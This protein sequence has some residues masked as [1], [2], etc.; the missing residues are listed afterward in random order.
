MKKDGHNLI[1]S[2][3]F[4]GVVALGLST[5]STESFAAELDD[6]SSQIPILEQS[7]NIGDISSTDSK[8]QTMKDAAEVVEGDA[9][10]EAGY[11]D[12]ANNAVETKNLDDE[13]S[14]EL[15][16]GG[17]DVLDQAE[18]KNDQVNEVYDDFV[19]EADEAAADFEY[20]AK[21]HGLEEY[22][23]KCNNTSDLQE[24]I[25][26]I[27]EAN[28]V[29]YSEV[30]RLKEE[31]AQ[32]EEELAKINS[33]ETEEYVRYQEASAKYDELLKE[34][35]EIHTEWLAL[36]EELGDGADVSPEVLAEY[37][38]RLNE[39]LQAKEAFEESNA[40][41]D[42]IYY[43]REQAEA[44]AENSETNAENW[45]S[46]LSDALSDRQVKRAAY[47]TADSRLKDIDKDGD[48]DK[49]KE[50][51]ELSAKHDKAYQAKESALNEKTNAEMDLESLVDE[52]ISKQMAV[53]DELRDANGFYSEFECYYAPY[54]DALS[55][56]SKAHDIKTRS[57]DAL[58][59]TRI[60]YSE[61]K[62]VIAEYK[63]NESGAI[64]YK[65]TLEEMQK[66]VDDIGATIDYE[67]AENDN[68]AVR[69]NYDKIAEATD[70]SADEFLKA[71]AENG[72][73]DY[74]SRIAAATTTDEKVALIDEA[75]AAYKEKLDSNADKSG[76]DADEYKALLEELAEYEAKY[77]EAEK[78]YNDAV[79]AYNQQIID[80]R[81]VYDNYQKSLIEQERLLAKKRVLD[82][83]SKE[84]QR[85][86]DTIDEKFYSPYD[87]DWYESLLRE[88]EERI[89]RYEALLF[90][91]KNTI[92]DVSEILGE[93]IEA[94]IQ[95]T[96]YSDLYKKVTRIDSEIE[97]LTAEYDSI[98][99]DLYAPY[100]IV[101]EAGYAYSEYFGD[102]EL[103]RDSAK[104]EFDGVSANL[105]DLQRQRYSY[106]YGED[107]SKIAGL[108][109]AAESYKEALQYNDEAKTLVAKAE[110]LT[111]ETEADYKLTSCSADV[112][113]EYNTVI[114]GKP[115]V[116]KGTISVFT[117]VADKALSSIHN[118]QELCQNARDTINVVVFVTISDI[119]GNELTSV[120][121]A[122]D[123]AA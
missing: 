2:L 99:S 45:Y 33:S 4:G 89:A 104:A 81:E 90:N 105:D 77:A 59:K 40:K 82:K 52:V 26:I 24:K 28:Q 25:D 95:R 36:K 27:D 72:L 117:R 1:K 94:N 86:K 51:A 64:N 67:Q 112:S 107:Y 54:R 29:A 53:H 17:K 102:L 97:D 70:S 20:S 41:F 98:D 38:L 48:L 106:A 31:E 60:T 76:I 83:R 118:V 56:L 11:L 37:E 115:V 49:R 114:E 39:F 47:D 14:E 116:V 68:Q 109:N 122:M 111:R 69:D 100:G 96:I 30:R 15:L 79:A 50:Y 42:E 10:A 84:L 80:N 18:E 19:E 92:S 9:V 120:V 91:S 71:A 58:Q 43:A 103:I 65:K 88:S 16:K 23:E 108:L 101:R 113:S 35:Q 32:L 5:N 121:R 78:N 93:Y 7:T 12:E 110:S 62:T 8:I 22:V 63:A 44:A 6:V 61:L 46:D 75:I 13:K 119:N 57:E 85:A 21:D 3:V 66:A 73:G 123:V 74:A 34:Y 55:N 87:N